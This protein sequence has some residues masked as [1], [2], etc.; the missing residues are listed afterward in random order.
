ML[1]PTSNYSSPS[2]RYGF[3]GQE[4]DDEIKGNG[5]S[6]NYKYRMHD[7]RVGR[8][9]AV[10]PL[11]NLY[12]HY[13]PYSFSGNKVI[14]YKELEGLEE[15]PA[16]L[17][18]E[19]FYKGI[20]EGIDRPDTIKPKKAGPIRT[21]INN[22]FDFVA[23]AF[24]EVMNT[25]SIAG[26]YAGDKVYDFVVNIPDENGHQGFYSDLPSVHEAI[27]SNDEG[28]IYASFANEQKA[29][30]AGTSAAYTQFMVDAILV[31]GAVEFI[32]VIPFT[33]FSTKIS[34]IDNVLSKEI[35]SFN[36]K[37]DAY[38]DCSDLASDLKKLDN[39]NGSI[40][41]ITAFYG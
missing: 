9:F 8:F 26:Q 37:K 21:T 24:G 30:I 32:A 35:S 18:D 10:D 23:S 5:N 11:T 13:T 40:V 33:K 15:T 14:A 17:S 1:V 6:I 38:I 34:K 27:M 16:Y 20:G 25:L 39:S 22:T 41:E 36:K 7:P 29:L 19:H 12:P 2:Y 4:K 28:M 31:E 3:Q